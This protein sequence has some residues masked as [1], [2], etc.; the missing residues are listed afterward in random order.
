MNTNPLYYVTVPI[1]RNDLISASRR[2]SSWSGAYHTACLALV[3]SLAG[4]NSA[5]EGPVT[6]PV[7]GTVTFDGS[8]VAEGRI[9]FRPTSGTQQAYSAEIREGRYQLDSEPG[10]ATV[11]ITA[12]R[13]IPGKFDTSNP[14]DEPQPIGEMYI[15]AKYNSQSTLV[16]EVSPTET[17]E[18]P[19]DLTSK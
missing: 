18:I 11:E 16:A 5:P 19:F 2:G 14:D 9:Q 3:M 15:P 12:S 8:P 17:N 1:R 7:S 10:S 13:P 4:C 6:F